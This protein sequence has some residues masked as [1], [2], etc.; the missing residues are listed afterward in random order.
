MDLIQAVKNGKTGGIVIVDDSYATPVGVASQETLSEVSNIIDTRPECYEALG[1]ALNL[2]AEHTHGDLMK[3]VEQGAA[4]L[5]PLYKAGGVAGEALEPLFADSKL[6]SLAHSEALKAIERFCEK[7]LRITP[8]TFASL[9]DAKLALSDCSIAFVDFRL[10]DGASNSESIM[11]HGQFAEH[12]KAR[13]TVEGIP[14]PKLIYLISSSLPN[15]AQLKAFR[16]ATGIRMAFFSS[17]RKSDIDESLLLSEVNKWKYK[18]PQ[19]FKL[20]GYINVV[21]T[22]IKEAAADLAKQLDAIELHELGMLNAFRLDV[23]GESLQEYLSWLVSEALASRIRSAPPMQ[24]KLLPSEGEIP[25]DGKAE[26][27]TALFELFSQIAVSP[28]STNTKAPRFGDIYRVMPKVKQG[29]TESTGAGVVSAQRR[30]LLVISPA[31]DLQRAKPEDSVLCVEGSETTPRASVFELTQRA[32]TLFGESVH[33]AKYM[34]GTKPKYTKLAWDKKRLVTLSVKELMAT[35]KYK[36]VARLSEMFAQEAKEQALST[37]SRVGLPVHPSFAASTEV[38]IRMKFGEVD[39]H[40]DFSASADFTC[41]VVLRGR[42]RDAKPNETQSF[43]A[44]TEQF[45]DWMRRD[46]LPMVKQR[47]EAPINAKFL[48][49]EKFFNDWRPGYQVE[50]SGSNRKAYLSGAL[51]F[52]LVDEIDTG[53]VANNVLDIQVRAS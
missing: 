40:H 11:G 46:F 38:F 6:K 32:S 49:V 20:D 16:D 35:K 18:Y 39:Q 15:R 3:A 25:L 17:L 45:A 47:F 53:D 26:V 23:E 2:A 7:K 30:V 19:S 24:N 44:F 10:H 1:K 51:S 36:K 21:S 5:W 37:A 43:I 42:R 48:N 27:G 34:D 41:A 14:A 31:C 28:I 8:K 50:L 13:P 52:G 29:D 9:D 22:T 33:L 12:Y 4:A